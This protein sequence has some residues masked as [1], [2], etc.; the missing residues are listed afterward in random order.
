MPKLNEGYTPRWIILL[1]DLGIVFFGIVIAYLLRF[2]FSIP[3]TELVDFPLVFPVVIGV[4]LISFLI[5]RIPWAI[6]R[7]MGQRDA[8]RI[9]ITIASGTALFFIIN[10]IYIF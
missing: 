5:A 1:I 3:K 9:L 2:D 8:A 4:R 7:Y 6:V 10:Q